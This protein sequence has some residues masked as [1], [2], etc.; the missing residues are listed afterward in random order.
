[1]SKEASDFKHNRIELEPRKLLCI[2]CLRG[3]WDCMDMSNLQE[4]LKTIENDPNIHIMMIGAFDEIGARTKLFEKQTPAQRC[5]D[6]DVLQRLGLC[7]GDTRMARDLFYR[8]SNLILSTEGICSYPD[9]EYGT[10]E[11]CGISRE[12]FYENGNK[13]LESAQSEDVMKT[14]KC[15]SVKA[16]DDADHIYIR[17]HHLLCLICFAG[18]KDNNKPIL[19]DNLYEAWMKFKNNPD[20]PVTIIEGASECCICPPCHGFVQERGL[21]VSPCH[22][23]DRKKDLDTMV[24]LGLSPGD[25]MSAGELYKRIYQKIPHIKL[26]CGYDKD[27]SYEWTSCQGAFSGHYER[28]LEKGILK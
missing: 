17:A 10:W 18:K 2:N 21:C 28:A 25:M 11:E 22:L 9:N 4:T 24:A 23:R 5:K 15:P 26:I 1:M 27:T 6:L 20:I 13:P 3:G 12:Q 16:L 14:I 7:F 8:I 19:E